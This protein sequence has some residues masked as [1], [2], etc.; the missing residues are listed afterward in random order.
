LEI[1]DSGVAHK[2][3]LQERMWLMHEPHHCKRPDACGAGDVN[4]DATQA[5]R[6][7]NLRTMNEMDLKM[8]VTMRAMAASGDARR[9]RQNAGVRG[10]EVARFLGVGAS[11]FHRWESGER[12]PSSADTLRWARVLQSLQEAP[13]GLDD[14]P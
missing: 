11:T 6:R 9:L 1:H 12:V 10:S 3:N 7:T 8:I 13:E 5:R 14:L 4:E 2:V